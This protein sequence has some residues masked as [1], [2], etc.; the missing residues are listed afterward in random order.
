MPAGSSVGS[1]FPSFQQAAEGPELASMIFQGISC[2]FMAE[3]A[4]M[5][6]S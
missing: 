4:G 1:S 6:R 5:W 2:G 3:P